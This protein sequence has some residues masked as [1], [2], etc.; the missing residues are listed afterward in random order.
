MNFGELKLAKGDL[1][2]F[3]SDGFEATV[4]HKYFFKTIYQPSDSLADQKFIPFSLSLAKQSPAEYG[5]ERTLIAVV[6]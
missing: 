6:Y 3:Y 2:V 5:K 4:R 1:I